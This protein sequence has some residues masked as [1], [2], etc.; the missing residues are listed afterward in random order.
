MKG[1]RYE[2]IFAVPLGQLDREQHFSGLG[3]TT[4][5]SSAPL[6]P[7]GSRLMY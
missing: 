3:L 7:V 6:K 1:E 2:A 4:A 5:L